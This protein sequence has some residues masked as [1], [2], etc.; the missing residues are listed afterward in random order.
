MSCRCEQFYDFG[1]FCIG[2]GCGPGS[3]GRTCFSNA[4]CPST[5]LPPYGGSKGA[6][7][8]GGSKGGV[9]P[10]K[11]YSIGPGLGKTQI[12]TTRVRLEDGTG[13]PVQRN[14]NTFNV[15]PEQ[16]QTNFAGDRILSKRRECPSGMTMNKEKGVC[17]QSG[18]YGNPVSSN[19]RAV[20][21]CCA[22]GCEDVQ[23]F[24]AF[25][26]GHNLRVGLF[27]L[28][29]LGD[30]VGCELTQYDTTQQLTDDVRYKF[31]NGFNFFVSGV[32]QETA[33][34]TSDGYLVI[35]DSEAMCENHP[36]SFAAYERCIFPFFA[37]TTCAGWYT[38]SDNP[39][40]QHDGEGWEWT[41]DVDA[42]YLCGNWQPKQ[43]G[44]SQS[45]G[46]F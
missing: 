21:P 3:A 20:L 9:T 18:G 39:G 32:A 5:A 2:T 29:T 22:Q 23:Y 19:T 26:D 1:G 7:G 44:E 41:G 11:G 14:D 40:G 8:G 46:P 31:M 10:P 30:A 36:Y 6:G 35:A 25:C 37:S 33:Y 17:I 15:H 45:K 4:D 34:C 42:P 43:S 16:Y 28:W 27:Y 13:R 12:P 38:P 24:E